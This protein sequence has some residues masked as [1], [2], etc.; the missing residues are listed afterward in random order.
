MTPVTS[1]LRSRLGWPMVA[2]IVVGD[3]LG[4]GI[5]FAPGELAGLSRA[6]WQVYFIWALA[7]FIT[8]CGALSLAEL[9]V[10]MPRA[11]AS[12][13][14]IREGFGPFWGFM[15]VWI[16]LWVSGPGSIA[17]IAAAWGSSGAIFFRS[18]HL[19]RLAI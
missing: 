16:N 6:H 14:F 15:L 1:P 4:S 9:S 11:G 18:H 2:A 19:S 13:H 17:G 3:M 5:F 12:Y 10:L 7:G 8:L